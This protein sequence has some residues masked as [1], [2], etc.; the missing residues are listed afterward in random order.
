MEN[1]AGDTRKA[2]CLEHSQVLEDKEQSL[3]DWQ[4]V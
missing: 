3:G 4:P 2:H 1:V